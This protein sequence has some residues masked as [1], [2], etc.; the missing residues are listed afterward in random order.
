MMN[1]LLIVCFALSL[2][3]CGGC[4][5]EPANKDAESGKESKI[6]ASLITDQTVEA[7]C[8][9]CKFGMAGDGCDLA[10]RIDGKSY[11]VDGAKLDDHGDAHAEDGMCNC[12]RK[13]KVTGE[14]KGERF[15]A[16]SFVLLP[17]EKKESDGKQ[18]SDDKK[19]NDGEQVAEKD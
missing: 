10:V 12:V 1:R 6:T 11:Y 9:E 15:V 2:F 3:V 14:I 17:T 7:S 4:Q 18:E 5:G 19:E 8:G 13:A 16:K